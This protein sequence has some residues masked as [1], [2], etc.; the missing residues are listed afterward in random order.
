VSWVYPD[1]FMPLMI[2]RK[3]Q[4]HHV[5]EGLSENMVLLGLV[6]TAKILNF[7]FIHYF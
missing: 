7:N 2:L 6:T 3:S 1:V 4:E 5:L